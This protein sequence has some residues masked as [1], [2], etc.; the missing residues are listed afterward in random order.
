MSRLDDISRNILINGGMS[1]FQRGTTATVTTT[2][3]Y[4]TAD[5][6]LL[7][8]SGTVTGTPQVFRS[9]DVPDGKSP[10]SLDFSLRRNASPVSAIL[11]QRIESSSIME[12]SNERVSL[13]FKYKSEIVDAVRVR[14]KIPTAADN[15]TTTAT[16]FDTTY[17]VVPSGGGSDIWKTFKLEGVLLPDVRLGLEVEISLSTPSGTDGAPVSHK[18][19]QIK[20]NVGRKARTFTP[21]GRNYTESLAACQRFYCVSTQYITRDNSVIMPF[22]VYWPV[23]MRATPSISLSGWPGSASVAVVNNNGYSGWYLPSSGSTGTVFA[24]AEI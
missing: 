23:T 2:P 18:I 10:W 11:A 7:S 5:R 17:S 21:Q 22:F 8:H 4:L 15:Y 13:S 14:L 1:V 16:V 3:N 12:F 9:S 24:N 19:S 6:F 20:M